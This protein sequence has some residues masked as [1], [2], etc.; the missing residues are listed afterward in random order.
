[1]TRARTGLRIIMMAAAL[2]LATATALGIPATAAQN[3]PTS[4]LTVAAKPSAVVPAALTPPSCQT[5][6]PAP[7]NAF[8][9]TTIVADNFESG[10]LSNWTVRTGGDGSADV[11]TSPVYTGGCAAHLHAT[12]A[13]GS[14]ANMSAAIPSGMAE[15]FGDG[16]F[17]ITTAAVNG[18]TNSYFRFFSGSTRIASVYRYANNGQLWLEVLSSSGTY[19]RTRLTSQAVSLSAWHRVQAAI[20]PN[21]TSTTV[22][23]W[24]DG[25][26]VYSD[27]GVD[28]PAVQVTA[29]TL[30]SEYNSQQG[31]IYLDDLVIKAADP[32]P[33]SC[34]A[35]APTNDQPG[36]TVVADGFECGNLAHW[37]V[38]MTGDGVAGVQSSPVH[39]GSLAASLVTSSVSPSLANLSQSLPAGTAEVYSDGWFDITAAGPAG[40]DVPYY[41]FFTGSTRFADVYRYN[42]TGQLWLRVLTPANTNSYTRLTSYSVPLDSW[43]RMQIHVVPNGAATTIQILF[44]GVQLYNS[45]SVNMAATSVSTVMLGAEHYPQP[46]SLSLDDIIL[47][48]VIP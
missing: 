25:T 6:T 28:G 27:S 1:M 12:T 7:G 34:D 39:D 30:G 8:P 42:S 19:V 37:V 22:E 13:K 17:N 33:A 14:L 46:G 15:V 45:S 24:L 16:W 4:V 23:V 26:R 44:D 5:T 9:G 31:D 36:Q 18:S 40:N 11:E 10:T 20:L 35:T 41:R 38:H 3:T 43:H 48:A 29:V 47:K 21:G 2:T 32:N